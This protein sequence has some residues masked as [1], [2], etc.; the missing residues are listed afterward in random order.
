MSQRL[1]VNSNGTNTNTI[2]RLTL[3]IVALGVTVALALDNDNPRRRRKA[4]SLTWIIDKPP[5]FSYNDDDAYNPGNWQNINVKDRAR[6]LT[7]P[8]DYKNHCNQL[9]VESPI[10]LETAR[11]EHCQSYRETEFYTPND[12]SCTI[13]DLRFDVTPFGLRSILYSSC[14]RPNISLPTDTETGPWEFRG[15]E[16]K[17]RSEHRVDGR[18]FDGELILS[19]TRGDDALFLSIMLEATSFRHEDHMEA[20]IARWEQTL[21]GDSVVCQ[22]PLEYDVLSN[23]E[24]PTGSPFPYDMIPS[25]SF[26]QYEGTLTVPPCTPGVT[27]VVHLKPMQI[28]RRQFNRLS[29]VMSGHV[30]PDSCE[31]GNSLSKHGENARPLQSPDFAQ[32]MLCQ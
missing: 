15:V 19:H 26:F 21:A 3:Q 22:T 25:P 7:V 29:T 16:L 2:M 30:Y 17:L 4:L 1:T 20:F 18:Q 5:T 23:K 12:S 8:A 24:Y 6:W 28:S 31:V 13:D 14:E 27:R 11:A 10:N 9:A 32:V